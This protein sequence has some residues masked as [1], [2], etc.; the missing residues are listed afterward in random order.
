M[1]CRNRYVNESRVMERACRCVRFI[2]RSAGRHA[3]ELL[4]QLAAALPELY[5]RRPHSCLLYLAAVL[6]DALAPPAD[7]QPHNVLLHA[8]LRD[9][10]HALLPRALQLLAQQDGL[11][12]NPDTVDDLFRLCVR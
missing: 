3:A 4:P 7:A 5:A 11:K 12:D 2:V 6:A 8:Q 1:L 9:L 10:L